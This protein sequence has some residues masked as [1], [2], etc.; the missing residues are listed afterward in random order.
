VHWK[1]NDQQDF[2]D[3]GQSV[4][5]E[6]PSGEAWREVTVDLPIDGLPQIVRLYLPADKSPLELR[7][8]RFQDAQGRKKVWEFSEVSP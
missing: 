7:S 4:H 3:T 5:Y 2:P 1:T 8:I 6:F